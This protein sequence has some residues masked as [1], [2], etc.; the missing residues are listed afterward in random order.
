MPDVQTYA[1]HRYLPKPTAIAF[2]FTLL[3][4]GCFVATY[5][6]VDAVRAGLLSLTLA[7]LVLTAISRAYIT[8]L[9]DRIIR[10]EMRMRG[11]AILSPSQLGLLEQLTMPQ[12]V[13]LRFASNAELPGLLERTVKERLSADHIKRAVVNWEADWHRT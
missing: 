13:A 7:V 9:Q 5:F 4:L 1:N 3:A 8:R 12:L 11:A 2:L 6:G 10:L